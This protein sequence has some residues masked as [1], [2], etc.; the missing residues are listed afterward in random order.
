[1]CCCEIALVDEGWGVLRG[2]MGWETKGWVMSW[3]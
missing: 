2:G 3:L 1:M